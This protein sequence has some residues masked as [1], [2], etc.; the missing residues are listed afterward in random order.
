MGTWGTGISSNDT[1]EDVY[2]EFFDLYNA[3]E[4]VEAISRKIIESNS[5]TIEDEDECNNFWF[6]LAKAQW[7]CKKLETELLQKVEKIILSGEDIETWKRLGGTNSDIKKRKIVLEKFLE[8]LKSEKKSAK[9][10][11]KKKIRQPAFEKGDCITFKLE[12]GNYGG[13]VVL[14]ANR[15]DEYGHNLIAVTRINQKRKPDKKTFENSEVLIINFA[16]W[17]EELAIKWY[18]PMRH[19]ESENLLEI[20]CKLDVNKEY[21]VH[22]ANFAFVA[23]FKI[24]II[25]LVNDQIKYERENSQPKLKKKLKD[26]IQRKK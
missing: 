5:E 25:D 9:R 2:V 8:K 7:D 21:N 12:N 20:S 24:W 11:K 1:Y 14:E 15:D 17:Q 26:F 3:G 19:K 23:D 22:N 4:E 16:N 6:A 13:V 10:R 18:N